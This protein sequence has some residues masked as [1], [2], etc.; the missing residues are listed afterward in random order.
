MEI[1]DTTIQDVLI[2]E[3]KVFKDSR[4]LF[5]E[6][7]NKENFNNVCNIDVNFVQENQSTSRLGTLRGLH[8]QLKRPQ[9]KLVRVSYGKVLDVVVDLRKSSKTYGKNFSIELSAESNN[10]LWIPPGMA[11]GFL[12]LSDYAIFNYLTTEYYYPSDEYTIIWN[13][14]FLNIDWELDGIVPKLSSKDQMGKMFK[15]SE[16]YD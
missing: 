2:I 1:R 13:D 14:S 12:T 10:Q 7:W 6:A 16:H 11:H 9:G 8:Y 15:E 3:P 5:F 4:G